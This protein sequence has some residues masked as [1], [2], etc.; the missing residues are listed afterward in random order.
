MYVVRARLEGPGAS[1]ITGAE[2]SLFCSARP[3]DGLEHV[4]VAHDKLGVHVT[5]FVLQPTAA[6]AMSAA[7]RIC[8]RV[9]E[10]F[11]V[12]QLLLVSC[13][14]GHLGQAD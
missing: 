10:S 14:P 11:G 12:G 1:L 4:H 6:D 2:H 7:I 8:K 9:C 5:L 13:E 3:A